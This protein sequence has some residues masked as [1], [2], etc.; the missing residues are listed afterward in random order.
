MLWIYFLDLPQMLPPLSINSPA[1]GNTP[2]PLAVLALV[3][4]V[5]VHGQGPSPL[6]EPIQLQG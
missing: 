1:Y 3:Q 2:F 6:M 4:T 5:L